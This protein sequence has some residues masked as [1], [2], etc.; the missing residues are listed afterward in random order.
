MVRGRVMM[1]ITLSGILSYYYRMK[2]HTRHRQRRQRRRHRTIRKRAIRQYGKGMEEWME[3]VTAA[4]QKTF[5]HFQHTAEYVSENNEPSINVSI[6][7]PREIIQKYDENTMISLAIR[8]NEMF[9]SSLIRCPDTANKKA[10]SGTD[11]LK[12]IILLGKELKHLGLKTIRLYDGSSID[13][14]MIKNNDSCSISL[15][16]YKILISKDH[17]SWYNSYGFKSNRYEDEVKNNATFAEQPMMTL[18]RM[19]SAYNIYRKKHP[20][21]YL[22]FLTKKSENVNRA[23]QW[24]NLENTRNT[25]VLIQTLLD[26]TEG[27]VTPDTPIKKGIEQIHRIALQ[28]R[29]CKDT[30]VTFYKNIIDAAAYYGIQY[31]RHLVYEL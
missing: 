9:I 3:S 10:M 15:A 18:L 21:G 5:P 14:P 6:Y 1:P 11:I 23:A 28:V 20:L 4:I 7:C 29:S 22:A 24:K 13:Y 30:I 27:R 19:T 31:N 16:L 17:H 12:Q 25:D 2:N 26:I 8:E